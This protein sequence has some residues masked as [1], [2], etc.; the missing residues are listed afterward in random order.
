MSYSWMTKLRQQSACQLHDG[1]LKMRNRLHH[2][3]IRLS[4]EDWDEV[5]ALAKDR[6]CTRSEIARLA[7]TLGIPL[8]KSATA[9]NHRRYAV[10]LEFL[11]SA[12]SAHIRR[13]LP[14]FEEEIQETML[15]RLEQ[16]HS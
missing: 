9:V 12:M 11:A 10:I 4:P 2:V 13:N 1:E 16:H 15:L 8:A 6:G 7:V 14:D 3:S 5:T